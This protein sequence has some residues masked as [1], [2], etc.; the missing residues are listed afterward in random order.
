LNPLEH[1]DPIGT[2]LF[3]LLGAPFGWA[4]PVPISPA[5]FHPGV[6]MRAGLVLTAAAGPVSNLVLALLATLALGLLARL[7]PESAVVGA[8]VVASGGLAQLL[9]TT[10]LLNVVL[11]VFNAIPIPP[12][13]GSRVVDG[14][15][16]DGLRP[17]WNG[18]SRLA[19]LALACVIV[20]PLLLGASPFE[21]PL[22]L[23]QAL[24]EAMLAVLAG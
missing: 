6:S 13:D 4:K 12:L 15:L 17:A 11:A 19:P 7:Q 10:I 24:V 9:Q 23:T 22:R 14:L 2:F 8:G 20:L 18:F 1:I 5:R 16:P 3:P 21:L